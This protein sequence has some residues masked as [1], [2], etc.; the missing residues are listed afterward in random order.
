MRKLLI[1]AL[2]L[3][4]CMAVA[5]Q[6][7]DFTKV[8]IKA[9]KVSGNIYLLQGAGGNIAASLGDDGILIVD[10]EYAPLADKIQAALKGIGVTDK[11][12]RF[13]VNTHYHGDHT[14]GDSAWGARG[15]T[16]IANENLR[17]RMESG[18]STGNG[19]A[20]KF[21][22][23]AQPKVALPVITFGDHVT[24]YLNDEEIRVMHFPAA[25]TDGDAVVYFTKN[26]VVHMGD[27]FIRYG[28]PFV[29]ILGGGSVQG[30]IA[31]CEKVAATLPA[32]V[33]V[34]PGHGELATMD[35]LRDY[36]KMMKDT[37]AVVQ[38]AM[39]KGETTDQMKSEKIL[40]AWQ[41]YSGAFVNTDAWIDT[42]Y[43]SL[44]LPA[45]KLN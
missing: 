31:A 10:T 41:K 40:A 43:N 28:F 14:N 33:K 23:A 15:A 45:A 16:I 11:P 1:A 12:V 3:I 29:D 32:D 26:N 35:D 20:V 17:K 36:T 27:E 39:A 4:P 8:E 25:H 7:P 44:K 38:A 37:M 30:M 18:S 9:S 2:L 24:V 42:L 6:T 19:G 34:I 13:V 22:S 21:Q 5:Q